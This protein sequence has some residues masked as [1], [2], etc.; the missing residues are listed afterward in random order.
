MSA[1][2]DYAAGAPSDMAPGARRAGELL[3]MDPDSG[4]AAARLRQTHVPN[5]C[6]KF[7]GQCR[8]PAP[9]RHDLRCG[10]CVRAYR[11]GTARTAAHHLAR[12]KVEQ[13]GAQTNVRVGSEQQERP[14]QPNEA[15][16]RRQPGAPSLWRPAAPTQ[17]A[18]RGDTPGSP[19]ETLGK[20]RLAAKRLEVGPARE[21]MLHPAQAR[22]DFR[23]KA[24]TYCK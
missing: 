18:W 6:R 13:C 16:C 14:E 12:H 15:R 24:S 8:R 23:P 19:G 9:A 10:F 4:I 5:A 7:A 22:S 11:S 2:S 3:D 17:P 1:A 21:T 20:W